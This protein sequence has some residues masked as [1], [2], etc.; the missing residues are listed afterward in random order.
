MTRQVRAPLASEAGFTLLEMLISVTIMLV[1][2]AGIFSV[3]NPAEGTFST[4]PEVSD[5]QQRLRVAADV[6]NRDLV[7]AGAGTYSGSAVGTL[8]NFFASV[9]PYRVGLQG[10]DPPGTFRADAISLLY[11]PS[12]AAQ[13]T[14]ADDMP[15]QS[16]E[17]KVNAQ[18]GCPV[19]D[20]LCGFETG[21]SVLIFDDTG[22]WETFT[23]TGVQT[24]ALHLQHRGQDFQKAYD[25][26]TYITH[27]MT[28]TYYLSTD[29]ATETYQLR[30]YDG[31]V[32][33]LPIVDNVVGLSFEYYG[34][35]Q[36]PML[37]KPVTDPKG[38]WTTYGPKPPA[39]G[40]DNEWDTYPAG[41]NCIF[42]LVGGQ[43][44][45]RLTALAGGNNI[46]R[47]DPGILTDGPWCPG[48]AT[49]NRYDADLLRVRQVRVSARVQAAAKGLRGPAG[50]LF[51]HPGTAT[52]A[53]RMAPDEQV[54]FDVTPR[55]LN[56]GR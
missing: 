42:T 22:A 27:V 43:H 16:S 40:V 41:E 31:G 45:S 46:V 44:T 24:S 2:T 28:H 19:G 3:M 36:P 8:S 26:N 37:K 18:A 55:N 5:M 10:A 4:Q 32:T 9:V 17:I 34:E 54:R 50:P 38:P 6:L 23:I 35:S 25:A 20:E 47:L 1:V 7:M 51:V 30:H 53:A 39:L 52:S 56:L 21:M 11:V 29:A 13:T 48:A 15:K 33:D 12:T 14:I 49:P